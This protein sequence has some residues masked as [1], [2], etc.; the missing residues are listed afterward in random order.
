MEWNEIEW[1]NEWT[2]DMEDVFMYLNVII[3]HIRFLSLYLWNS[4]NYFYQNEN[5]NQIKPN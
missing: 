4:I 2:D 3:S 1:V 5:K